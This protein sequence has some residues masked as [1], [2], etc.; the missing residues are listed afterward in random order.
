MQI[1]SRHFISPLVAVI[2]LALGVAFAGATN[3]ILSLLSFQAIGGGVIR[4]APLVVRPGDN[5]DP[6]ASS[7]PELSC[8][9]L[10][11]LPVWHE[12][13]NDARF[14]ER[15]QFYAGPLN[16]SEMVQVKRLDLNRD[17]NDESLVSGK[18]TLCGATGNCVYWV[19]GLKDGVVRTVLVAVHETDAHEFGV[20]EVHKSRTRGYSDILLTDRNGQNVLSFRTYRFDG[21][22][23]VESR[24]M[25]EVPRLLRDGAGSWELITCDE[26]Y[27][28]SDQMRESLLRTAD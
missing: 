13:K 3:A 10:D 20:D 12:L 7:K 16:C 19:F 11:I 14:K 22:Q 5:T 4:E 2:T 26:F 1:S 6:I 18:G 17:G 15:L 25:A 23:Y 28:R 24:C 21:T 8:Y 9:D 27:R